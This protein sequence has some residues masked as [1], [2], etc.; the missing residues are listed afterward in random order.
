MPNMNDENAPV[1]PPQEAIARRAYELFLQRGSV[2]GYELDDW[3][4]AE[5][6]LTAEAA[7]G[8]IADSQDTGAGESPGGG[9]SGRR[10]S[11]RER[12]TPRRTLRP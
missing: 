9:R 12:A 6:E 7:K 8:S 11:T 2:P 5:A 3:L 4:Q 10:P 1:Q